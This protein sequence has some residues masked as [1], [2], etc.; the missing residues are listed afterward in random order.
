MGTDKKD[1]STIRKAV[2]ES[3]DENVTLLNYKKDGS[4]FVNDFFICPL[5]SINDGRTTSECSTRKFPQRAKR[6][7]TRAHCK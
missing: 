3:K 1:V 2:N 5:H 4:T 6:F 7:P